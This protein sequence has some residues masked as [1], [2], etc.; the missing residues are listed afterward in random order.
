M[1]S[2]QRAPVRTTSCPFW[3]RVRKKK[4]VLQ[5]VENFKIYMDNPPGAERFRKGVMGGG[6][7]WFTARTFVIYE[8]PHLKNRTKNRTK[9]NRTWKVHAKHFVAPFYCA[10]A[11]SCVKFEIVVNNYPNGRNAMGRIEPQ[12]PSNHFAQTPLLRGRVFFCQTVNL[13]AGNVAICN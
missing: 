11:C 2:P 6:V 10:S 8:P 7:P 9:P 3:P 4:E 13:E 5:I 1:R 12:S